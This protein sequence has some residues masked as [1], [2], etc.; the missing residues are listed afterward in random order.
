M[1]AID[2]LLQLE[3]EPS[4]QTRERL[5]HERE[6]LVR[7]P[8]VELFTDVAAADE[9]YERF[10]VWRYGK[11]AWWWQHQCG[12]VRVESPVELSVRF[13]LDGLWIGGGWGYATSSQVTRY[14]HAVD[15][16]TSGAELVE[17]VD[18]L[19]DMD[20]D[21][22]GAMLKR[23]PR[24]YPAEHPRGELLRHRSLAARRLI[25]DETVL[26]SSAAVGAVLETYALIRRL[27]DWQAEHIADV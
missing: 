27:I 7:R 20:F 10:S 22:G 4:V 17:I 15:D 8:M 14:R 1:A 9:A 11:T 13:D 12:I 2:V 16:D 26:H 21:V 18:A 5:R 23:V 3:G 25:D 19:R 6:H 24:D